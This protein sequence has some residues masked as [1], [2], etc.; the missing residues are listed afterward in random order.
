MRYVISR[1]GL[2]NCV[3]DH[4]SYCCITV[5]RSNANTR[6]NHLPLIKFWRGITTLL[7]PYCEYVLLWLTLNQRKRK[8]PQNWAT[9]LR[10]KQIRT[11]KIL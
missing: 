10:Y 7:Y 1:I 6:R 9:E 4:G 3:T 2:K 5:S 8:N 11:Y